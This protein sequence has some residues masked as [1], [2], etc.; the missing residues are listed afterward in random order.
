MKTL[1]LDIDGV[2]TNVFTDRLNEKFGPAYFPREYD[3]RLSR[4][5]VAELMG[6]TL[7][8]PWFYSDAKPID[9]A[10]WGVNSIRSMFNIRHIDIFVVTARPEKVKGCTISFL[11]SIN[12]PVDGVKHVPFQSKPRFIHEMN[13]DMVIE[14]AP[15]HT[16]ALRTLGVPYMIFDQ[17]W[18]QGAI[19]PRLN[20]WADWRKV[21]EGMDK[22]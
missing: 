3:L 12:M 2:L 16:E 10:V 17:P 11:T 8:D 9:L 15:H 1:V 7:D 6:A 18:N 19:G 4:P 5:D 21:V 20:S 22:Q 14:D 13:P